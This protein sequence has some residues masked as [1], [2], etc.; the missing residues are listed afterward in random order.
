[1][2]GVT[3]KVRCCGKLHRVT[4]LRSGAIV[5]HDHPKDNDATGAAAIL[6]GVKPKCVEIKEAVIQA[7]QHPYSDKV[8]MRPVDN[9]LKNITESLRLSLRELIRQGRG[10]KPRKPLVG[11][12]RLEH[13]QINKIG[14]ALNVAARTHAYD[15]EKLEVLCSFEQIE[16]PKIQPHVHCWVGKGHRFKRIMVDVWFRRDEAWRAYKLCRCAARLE[17]G[18]MLPVIQATTDGA[19]KGYCFGLAFRVRMK[20]Q[21]ALCPLLIALPEDKGPGRFISWLTE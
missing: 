1:M 3:I 2:N 19:P 12:E 5:L 21:S 16:S 10:W 20:K 18:T 9:R 11:R 17:D 8:W 7:I 6:A 13:G 4:V 15:S 14:K